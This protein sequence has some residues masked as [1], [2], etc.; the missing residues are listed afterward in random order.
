[1]LRTPHQPSSPPASPRPAAEEE[2]VIGYHDV[3]LG[4]VELECAVDLETHT[5]TAQVSHFTQFAI[6]GKVTLPPAA[7]AVTDLTISP[8]TAD[9]GESATISAQ[10]TNTGGVEGTYAVSLEIESQVDT[11]EAVGGVPGKQHQ[12]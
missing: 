6:L 3:A 5:V 12:A 11:I 2:L 9:P 10:V 8:P 1:M 7:F 4:W